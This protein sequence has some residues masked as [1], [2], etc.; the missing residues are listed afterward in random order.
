MEE[1][2]PKYSTI[3]DQKLNHDFF[4]LRFYSS[5]YYSAINDYLREKKIQTFTEEQIKSWI[6]CL[7]LALKRNLGVKDDTIVYRGIKKF[8]FSQEI[9]IG[10]QFYFREFFSTSLKEEKA[11]DFAGFSKYG[12]GT[13]MV[14][15]IKNNGTNGHPNYCY[16]ITEISCFEKEKEILLSSHC[17]FTIT[18]IIRNKIY[19]FDYVYLTC[20]G[21]LLDEI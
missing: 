4:V 16:D 21:Y 9:G 15:T 14:I 7:Q 6:C 10:S 18:N 3:N 19:K 20:N 2:Y 12:T 1:K 13:I 11:K 17:Y 8:K 5:K